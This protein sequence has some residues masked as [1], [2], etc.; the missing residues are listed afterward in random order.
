MYTNFKILPNLY[1]TGLNQIFLRVSTRFFI[2]QLGY[3]LGQFIPGLI[4]TKYIAISRERRSKNGYKQGRAMNWLVM[5]S[6]GMN[7]LGAFRL[8]FLQF[9]L[10]LKGL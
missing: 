2:G 5:N 6:P 3:A 8:D 1:K 4:I 7:C 10:L 9:W